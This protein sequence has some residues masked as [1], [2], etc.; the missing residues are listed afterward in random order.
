MHPLRINLVILV[1]LQP[2]EKNKKTKENGMHTYL[3]QKSIV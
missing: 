1:K 3:A 2:K